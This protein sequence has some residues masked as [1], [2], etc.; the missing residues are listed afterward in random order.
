[1]EFK[2]AIEIYFILFIY[3]LVKNK[4]QLNFKINRNF[5]CI[6]ILINCI[7]CNVSMADK[8]D[9]SI[10]HEKSKT[11]QIKDFD[12]PSPD[13]RDDIE[14]DTTSPNRRITP[15][16]S[17]SNNQVPVASQS[18]NAPPNI[19][20][21]E[22]SQELFIEP[23]G[24][25]KGNKNKS[26]NQ[27]HLSLST[28]LVN[29]A[30]SNSISVGQ[31]RK[32]L[33]PSK[34]ITTHRNFDPRL[35]NQN[36]TKQSVLNIPS[37]PS[38]IIINQN[39]TAPANILKHTI[40][41]S[42]TNNQ[43]NSNIETI[44]DIKLDDQQ[45]E[46]VAKWVAQA[47]DN[48]HLH[49]NEFEKFVCDTAFN[50]KIPL[51]VFKKLVAE[52]RHQ[53]A[54]FAYERLTTL[55]ENTTITMEKLNSANATIEQLQQQQLSSHRT[56]VLNDSS[57]ANI[58]DYVLFANKYFT[59]D[60]EYEYTDFQKTVVITPVPSRF[61][62]DFWPSFCQDQKIPLCPIYFHP[63]GF[64]FSQG[65]PVGVMHEKSKGVDGSY[66]GITLN[67][68]KL[69]AN[70]SLYDCKN[71]KD[72][73][74]YPIPTNK[75]DETLVLPNL[76]TIVQYVVGNESLMGGA[77]LEHCGNQ[78]RKNL[79]QLNNSPLLPNTIKTA[80][81]TY[82]F[83]V[84]HSINQMF[85]RI[86]DRRWPNG[87]LVRIWHQFRHAI[88]AL[89]GSYTT[90]DEIYPSQ[91][92]SMDQI[93][94][95]SNEMLRNKCCAL[96]L[97]NYNK[98]AKKYSKPNPN[99]HPIWQAIAFGFFDSL[100]EISI[101]LRDIPQ[102]RPS[103]EDIF[104][105]NNMHHTSQ[106]MGNKGYHWCLTPINGLPFFIQGDIAI[107]AFGKNHQMVFKHT[108]AEKTVTFQRQLQVSPKTWN[109]DHLYSNITYDGAWTVVLHYG[110]IDLSE[111]ALSWLIS[112]QK[113]MP[114]NLDHARYLFNIKDDNKPWRPPLWYHRL[115]PPIF[116]STSQICYILSQKTE[117]TPAFHR[118]SFDNLKTLLFEDSNRHCDL[119]TSY[120]YIFIPRFIKLLDTLKVS[121]NRAEYTSID[122]SDNITW[123]HD[124]DNDTRSETDGR[125]DNFV[126]NPWVCSVSEMIATFNRNCDMNVSKNLIGHEKLIYD[127]SDDYNDNQNNNNNNNNNNNASI[128]IND[129]PFKLTN[130]E[131]ERNTSF[132][133][134]TYPKHSQS[135]VSAPTNLS[136]QHNMVTNARGQV[137][138]WAQHQ[139]NLRSQ[140]ATLNQ[141]SV[142]LD[143]TNYFVWRKQVKNTMPLI[144]DLDWDQVRETLVRQK[145]SQTIRD[146][147]TNPLSNKDI[148]EKKSS[149]DSWLDALRRIINP[150]LDLQAD[151]D[152][153]RN[154]VFT[155]KDMPFSQ[156]LIRFQ[157]YL[158][159]FHED[160]KYAK[161]Y[162]LTTAS[163]A[164]VTDLD[165]LE[166]FTL[167]L[168]L[169]A[170]PHLATYVSSAIASAK[171]QQSFNPLMLALSQYDT[172]HTRA[173]NSVWVHLEQ[174]K[175]CHFQS[176]NPQSHE[177]ITM[178]SNTNIQSLSNP[179]D[180]M[181]E[182]NFQH[183]NKNKARGKNKF[184]AN[185]NRGATFP[186]SAN[187]G[188]G[189]S[190]PRFNNHNTQ[191]AVKNVKFDF[192]ENY[193]P[194]HKNSEFY[195]KINHTPETWHQGFNFNNPWRNYDI[196][197][198]HPKA[199]PSQSRYRMAY[200][201]DGPCDTCKFTGHKPWDCPLWLH[202]RKLNSTMTPKGIKYEKYVSRLLKARTVSEL[203]CTVKSDR[204]FYAS[205]NN[206]H[207]FTQAN[208]NDTT[209]DV[210]TNDNS[211][212]N[213]NNNLNNNN[214]PS[215]NF[216]ENLSSFTFSN[217]TFGITQP[218]STNVS[219]PNP[220]MQPR[221][222]KPNKGPNCENLPFEVT[223]PV[224]NCLWTDNPHFETKKY[225]QFDIDAQNVTNPHFCRMFLWVNLGVL[226]LA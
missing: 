96:S 75:N 97:F 159:R 63:C 183:R 120:N 184:R 23:S 3:F 195:A 42:Q 85:S 61:K 225:I 4:S 115:T 150:K 14:F 69:K 185:N 76:H 22:N 176:T 202:F 86:D 168:Q 67:N 1:M 90:A 55:Q 181:L 70:G 10:S 199:K 20:N 7:L 209:V 11:E 226:L 64:W 83:N 46:N 165:I 179:N 44:E 146:I 25:N 21:N 136:L 6:F 174:T 8:M 131:N 65:Y 197:K 43:N 193:Q 190:Q 175:G 119:P 177:S 59:F 56:P 147:L 137:I 121:L 88:Y 149:I 191:K 133:S 49:P 127:L 215:I 152:R 66:F 162:H 13:A 189:K 161:T 71:N 198:R 51:P 140:M 204:D 122:V 112:S 35:N 18:H 201:W 62:N 39:N 93:K 178:N 207:Y 145:M 188:Y 81:G 118:L 101:V 41:N 163:M 5:I 132:S 72:I 91:Y 34:P 92:A 144:S 113:H 114:K 30:K 164:Q 186:H 211:N 84:S 27:R 138:S 107:E 187:P 110:P 32:Q 180:D 24:K 104:N 170:P 160:L 19:L 33:L 54:I 94:L 156:Q 98:Y 74:S 223:P 124:N 102:P 157:H 52:L 148:E 192:R 87:P 129:D 100:I 12:T 167:N 77:K 58:H 154:W 208:D 48:L 203:N 103:D 194:S 89:L 169:K 37:N 210:I 218:R 214:Q 80:I 153:L 105:L 95:I 99:T 116:K 142:S 17:P 123:K 45:N 171:Q 224:L 108:P 130:I 26:S 206:N 31:L 155:P 143:Y 47:K 213:N 221:G 29:V 106:L 2:F 217:P 212:D 219:T 82:Y 172:Q 50:F 135:Q 141:I 139:F 200:Y 38:R 111:R 57:K 78:V 36:K 134:F 196:T 53:H 117:Y 220:L 68:L 128:S 205:N 173:P 166:V 16:E 9:I 79:K 60:L 182:A 216:N 126:C 73:C 222:P 28:S 40:N 151:L 15:I 158:N 109:L 125:H